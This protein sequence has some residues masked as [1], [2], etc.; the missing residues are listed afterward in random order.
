MRG[1]R[2]AHDGIRLCERLAPRPATV[3]LRRRDRFGDDHRDRRRGLSRAA[4]LTVPADGG[5]ARRLTSYG[6]GERRPARLA[7]RLP[8]SGQVVSAANDAGT[9]ARLVRRPRRPQGPTGE[10]RL[11]PDKGLVDLS[12]LTAVEAPDDRLPKSPSG[13]MSLRRRAGSGSGGLD[14]RR[15]MT[16]DPAVIGLGSFA[17]A[18]ILPVADPRL[19]SAG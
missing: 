14:Q 8:R 12:T 1:R 17:A 7:A 19:V 5:V 4:R 10:D 6:R 18:G 11:V 13:R 9:R 15:A 3:A 16:R 2:L